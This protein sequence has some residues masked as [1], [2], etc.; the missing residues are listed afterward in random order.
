[1]DYQR[2]S[3]EHWGRATNLHFLTFSMIGMISQNT[4]TKLQGRSKIR[5]SSSFR[6]VRCTPFLQSIR[7]R[8]RESPRSHL[9]I[10]EVSTLPVMSCEGRSED[11]T[12]IISISFSKRLPDQGWCYLLLGDLRFSKPAG[13]R[14]PEGAL[15]VRRSD[16]RKPSLRSWR[17]VWPA[18]D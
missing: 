6:L 4:S 13:P 17:P 16:F 5:L 2:I 7:D 15:R 10:F 3:I 12:N 14:S 1:M 18:W 8:S 9:H 11:M